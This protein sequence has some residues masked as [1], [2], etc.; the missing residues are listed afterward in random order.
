MKSTVRAI[1]IAICVVFFA[2]LNLSPWCIRRTVSAQKDA[3]YEPEVV[4]LFV[5]TCLC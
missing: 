3:V 4:P 1:L 2:F 5:D